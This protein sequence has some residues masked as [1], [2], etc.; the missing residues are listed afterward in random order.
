[1]DVSFSRPEPHA[2]IGSFDESIFPPDVIKINGASIFKNNGG[3]Y[4]RFIR[5]CRPV[6]LDRIASW[7]IE[8]MAGDSH[9]KFAELRIFISRR[10]LII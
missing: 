5:M 6:E 1:M 8:G 10:K 7:H 4:G 9:V 3:K 2:E